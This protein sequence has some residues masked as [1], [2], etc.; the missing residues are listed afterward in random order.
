MLP[1]SLTPDLFEG[2]A[3]VGLVPFAM[4]RLRPMIGGRSVPMP[5]GV[6]SFTEVNVR[7]YVRGPRGPGVWFSSLDATS[8]LAVGVA[9]LAWALPY[10]R[11]EV[12]A[13]VDESSRRWDIRRH[14]GTTGRLAVSVG[15]RRP[16]DELDSFL[17]ARFALYAQ[18]LWT[19]RLLWCPVAHDPWRLHDAE[20]QDVDTGLVGA[21]GLAPVGAPLVVVAEPVDVRVGLPELIRVGRGSAQVGYDRP[22]TRV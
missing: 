22:S 19:Q 16:A 13:S 18:P 7:T 11:A 3:W 1:P 14:D 17:T 5:G 6:E 4:Q 2:K 10:R 8:V 9:R 20:L 21:A 12:E 15:S